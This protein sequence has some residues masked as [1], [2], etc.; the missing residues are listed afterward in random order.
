MGQPKA[1][2]LFPLIVAYGALLI[3][4]APPGTTPPSSLPSLPALTSLPPHAPSATFEE[5]GCLLPCSTGSCQNVWINVQT[6]DQCNTISNFISCGDCKSAETSQDILL[7]VNISSGF[8][9][10]CPEPPQKFCPGL[11][12]P[13]DACTQPDDCAIPDG[14]TKGVCIRSFYLNPDLHSSSACQSGQ[15][16]QYC[17][18][19]SHCVSN[20]CR[21]HYKGYDTHIRGLCS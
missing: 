13:G 5:N 19:D 9:T 2:F 8:V 3:S 12:Q 10:L 15:M 4:A 7:T 1:R 20:H 14:L 18:E 6:E 16:G 17:R 21:N 11:Q